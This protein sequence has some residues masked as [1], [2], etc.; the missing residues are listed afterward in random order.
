MSC[1]SEVLGRLKMCWARCRLICL[2]TNSSPSGRDSTLMM[3]R[4]RQRNPEP[5][6]EHTSS[7]MARDIIEHL[8]VL[9]G[10]TQPSVTDFKP[11]GTA[12]DCDLRDHGIVRFQALCLAHTQRFFMNRSAAFKEQQMDR[13]S[14]II[15]WCR[16]TRKWRCLMSFCKAWNLCPLRLFTCSR[17]GGVSESN[18]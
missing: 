2:L 18:S 6:R 1:C 16:R 13:D 3:A 8:F 7:Q 11:N 4:C 9:K 17:G 12:E 15:V 5:V 10:Q 14:C